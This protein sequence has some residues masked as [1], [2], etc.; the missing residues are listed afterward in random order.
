MGLFTTVTTRKIPRWN[1]LIYYHGSLSGTLNNI[2]LTNTFFPL[3][4]GLSSSGCIT[5][6]AKA[7]NIET[8]LLVPIKTD[9]KI[10]LIH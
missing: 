1:I 5:G 6:T 9:G 8:G 7:F 10:A 3:Y 2:K 4:Y